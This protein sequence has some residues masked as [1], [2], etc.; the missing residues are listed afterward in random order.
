MQNANL[1]IRRAAVLNIP[2]RDAAALLEA[3]NGDAALLYLHILKNG[4][5]LRAEQAATELHRSDRDIEI[6]AGRLRQM[7][8]LSSG[9]A[10]QPL[11]EPAQELPE[12]RAQEVS[13]RSMEDKDFQWLVSETQTSLG[14][15]LSSTD[16][17]KL[18]GIYDELGLPPEVIIML[19]NYCRKQSYERYGRERTVGFAAIEK[20]AYIWVNRE[21]VTLEQ[22]DRWIAEQNRRSELFSQLRKEFGL[23]DR[24]FAKTERDYLSKW[25]DMG[26]PAESIAI[27]ADRTITNT[28]KL[29]WSYMDSIIRSW[30]GMGLHTA[31]QIEQKDPRSID[32]RSTDDAKA[33]E[34]PRDDSK[35]LQ[36]LARIRERMK[37]T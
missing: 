7:G 3:G 18:F 29:N 6:A 8:I 27:A 9:E 16:L 37:N 33:P 36:Q 28:G 20:E 32:R 12:Y 15:I 19:V 11:P 5:V 1:T 17:K 13:R 35:A 26:F 34:P 2:L 22:A 14:R 25:L 23:R 31:E 21:I 10:N 24:D 4:G 30:H